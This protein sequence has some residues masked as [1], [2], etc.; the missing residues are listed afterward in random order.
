MFEVAA[1]YLEAFQT[2][3]AAEERLEI[4][5]FKASFHGAAEMHRHADI[6]PT[7]SRDRSEETNRLAVLSHR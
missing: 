5:V 4:H 1:N 6:N 7:S 2:I 3:L